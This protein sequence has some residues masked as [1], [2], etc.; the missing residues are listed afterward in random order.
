MDAFI[1]NHLSLV[2]S[3]LYLIVGLSL[4]AYVGLYVPAKAKY[5]DLIEAQKYIAAENAELKKRKAFFTKSNK[6]TVNK[7]NSIPDFL[8]RINKLANDHKV[9]IRKFVPDEEDKLKFIIEMFGNYYVFTQFAADLES[10]DVVVHDLEVRPYDSKKSINFIKFA[11]TP[12]NDARP[13][14][15]RHFD[16]L[17]AMVK[18]K[19][20][21]NPFQRLVDIPG[22]DCID[23]TWVHTL[24]GIGTISGKKVATINSLDYG[25][26]DVLK[27]T[28]LKIVSIGSDRVE[29]VKQTAN[30][31][32]CHILKFQQKKTKTRERGLR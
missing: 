25:I 7:L 22:R 20:R 2:L 24:S 11:I 8:K 12:K 4:A 31:K 9:I 17:L 28:G 29:F 27:P 15:P 19:N 26:G 23:Q 6:E 5:A 10:L 30:A 21:R 18:Q 14:P 1:R 32:E 16:T 3:T 13:A